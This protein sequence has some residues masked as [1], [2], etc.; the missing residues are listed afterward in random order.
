[1]NH[2]EIMN[3]LKVSKKRVERYNKAILREQETQRTL[4]QELGSDVSSATGEAIG[5]VS[6]KPVNTNYNRQ[7]IAARVVELRDGQKMSFT[8]IAATLNTEGYKPRTAASFSQ[9]TVF[10]LYK[11][12]MKTAIAAA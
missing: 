12:V 9:A 3:K 8:T 11:S 6:K 2:V 4:L 10:Q 7:E 1:M 5:G